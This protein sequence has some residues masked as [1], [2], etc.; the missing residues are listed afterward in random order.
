M[1]KVLRKRLEPSAVT[2]LLLQAS[3]MQEFCETYQWTWHQ[4][5]GKKLNYASVAR[6]AGFRSRSTVRDFLVGRR[7]LSVAGLSSLAKA[8]GFNPFQ[9]KVFL[10]LSHDSSSNGSALLELQKR[11]TKLRQSERI[12][13]SETA[14]SIFENVR[15][16]VL[17]AALGSFERG[18]DVHEIQSRTGYSRTV[19]SALLDDLIRIGLARY[20]A[21]SDRYFAVQAHLDYRRQHQLGFRLYYQSLMSKL[22]RAS[23]KKE[24]ATDSL[25]HGANFSVCS[26]SLPEKLERLRE[27]LVEWIQSSEDEEGDIIVNLAV[28]VSPEAAGL[29]KAF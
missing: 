7:T 1:E 9:R 21:R 19:L 12:S 11:K 26:G 24:D 17:Y 2:K 4:E 23:E 10:A 28:G 14:S 5:T 15:F 27:M 20:D 6:K 18:S 8:L 3:S 13:R 16:P 25:F 22:S 29:K